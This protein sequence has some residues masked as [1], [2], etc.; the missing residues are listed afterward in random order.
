MD[1]A[2][3]VARGFRSRLADVA[4]TR[5]MPSHAVRGSS[6]VVQ[7]VSLE[8]RRRVACIL[9]VL[10]QGGLLVT[11]GGTS[12]RAV[13]G[14]GRW[15]GGITIVECGGLGASAS[16]RELI[17]FTFSTASS[18]SRASRVETAATLGHEDG[19]SQSTTRMQPA[20]GGE[21]IGSE[22]ISSDGRGLF[23]RSV[24]ALPAW[25][26]RPEHLD[27]HAA[28]DPHGVVSSVEWLLIVVC[29]YTIAVV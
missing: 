2:G 8:T 19:A 18:R 9:G 11:S 10:G 17:F 29:V 20:S 4:G 21:W 22:V 27:E 25:P 6:T 15:C 23:C 16:C 14:S 7:S 26:F 24:C 13:M 28:P 3:K 1:C 12:T 5:M